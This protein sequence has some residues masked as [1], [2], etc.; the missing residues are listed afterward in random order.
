MKNLGTI[1]ITLLLLLACKKDKVPPPCIGVSM[2]GER[3]LFVGT[4]H[5]YRT[6]VEE[7]FDIGP[8]IYYDYTPQT[9]GFDYYFTIS[10]DGFYKGYRNNVLVHDIILSSV[11]FEIFGGLNTSGMSFI[12]DC[13]EYDF[14]SLVMQNS[15]VTQDTIHTRE[16]PL[17]FDDQE[18]HLKSGQNYFVKE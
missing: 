12:L 4:W 1:L 6:S 18:N 15:N 8:S 16:Y 5:W 11:E 10:E 13:G 3:T 2:T 7:W 14:F 9:E 17:N